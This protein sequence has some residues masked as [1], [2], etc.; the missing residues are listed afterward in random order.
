MTG[1]A[2]AEEVEAGGVLEAH[3]R[4][5]IIRATPHYLALARMIGE[6]ISKGFTLRAFR[7]LRATGA[8]D[9]Y[10]HEIIEGWNSD[11]VLELS[12]KLTG[13]ALGGLAVTVPEVHALRLSYF[14]EGFG[15]G[16]HPWSEVLRRVLEDD[17]ARHPEDYEA[18]KAGALELLRRRPAAGH[19][20]SE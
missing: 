1:E 9:R 6:Q 17:R 18:A 12:S 13:G 7:M 19:R 5:S 11:R 16:S 15:L 3:R 8:P 2:E 20:R 4:I 14:V 10:A